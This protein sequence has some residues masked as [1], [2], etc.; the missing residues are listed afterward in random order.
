MTTSIETTPESRR[1]KVKPSFTRALFW[2]LFPIISIV[3]LVLWL[4]PSNA[5]ADN[6]LKLVAL[7]T[8]WPVVLG[9]VAF[10]FLVSFDDE[11]SAYI[12]NAKLK[13][14]DL[15][16][17]QQQPN[18]PLPVIEAVR[19]KEDLLLRER[20]DAGAPVA[21]RESTT[22][23]GEKA[24]L[25]AEIQ[26]RDIESRKWMHLYLDSF[27]VDRSKSVLTWISSF[28]RPIPKQFFNSKWEKF[29]AAPTERSQ[30]LRL[31]AELG[32]IR[33]E[34]NNIS[35]TPEGRGYLEHLVEI[36]EESG[37]PAVWPH[38]FISREDAAQFS[39]APRA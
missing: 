28:Q 16:V 21:V 4:S 18:A 6:L 5:R 10:G 38:P 13:Y 11:L 14:R 27:L 36:A 23:T 9:A 25:V 8:S 19:E 35:L 37:Q 22:G 39:E 17:M 3:G 20:L 34:S 29:F 26:R 1:P 7:L 31:L 32:L 2:T 15:E 33:T 24:H 30:T 12:R